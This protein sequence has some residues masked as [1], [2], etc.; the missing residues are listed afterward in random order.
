MADY[1][2]LRDARTNRN[3]AIT[4]ANTASVVLYNASAG[5]PNTSANTANHHPARPGS[6]KA[7]HRSRQRRPAQYLEVNHQTQVR[8]HLAFPTA[9]LIH[10]DADPLRI[11]HEAITRA[12]TGGQP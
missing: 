9:R 5:N 7:D 11:L 4:T 12:I 10:A 6:N 3:P 1:Q 8:T 2:A